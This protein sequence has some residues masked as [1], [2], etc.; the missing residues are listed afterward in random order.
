MCEQCV[1]IDKKIEW[2]RNIQ[3]SIGNQATIDAAE[4][5]IADLAAQKATLHLERSPSG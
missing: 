5:F 1:E 3:R 4:K 2:Y